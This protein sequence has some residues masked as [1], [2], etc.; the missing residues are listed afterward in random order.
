MT[1]V[2]LW[3]LL[4]TNPQEAGSRKEGGRTS[5]FLFVPQ[6]AIKRVCICSGPY[7]PSR[8]KLSQLHSLP[9]RKFYAQ[10]LILPSSDERDQA[11][12]NVPTNGSIFMTRSRAEPSTQA[13]GNKTLI[14]GKIRMEE[15]QTAL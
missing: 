13:A 15:F 14:Q 6:K 2:H 5:G 3:R 9:N 8:S 11:G 10:F 7:S 1:H 4:F 12:V